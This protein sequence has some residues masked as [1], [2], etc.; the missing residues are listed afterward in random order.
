MVIFSPTHT[1]RTHCLRLRSLLNIVE[2]I[3]GVYKD[4]CA[5]WKIFFSGGTGKV[6]TRLHEYQCGIKVSEKYFQIWI[7]KV[8]KA[9]VH[10]HSENGWFT[11]GCELT[12]TKN[13]IYYSWVAKE[14]MNAWLL[15][16]W[17]AHTIDKWHHSLIETK[18]KWENVHAFT[19]ILEWV[20]GNRV[21]KI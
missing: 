5:S 8:E 21:Q 9:S 3:S 7:Q 12:W 17:L 16:Q 10:S 15:Y 14:W 13:A 1:L 19:M 20:I 2:S 6:S 4:Q 11:L 18:T